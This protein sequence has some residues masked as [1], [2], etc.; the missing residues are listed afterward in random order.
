MRKHD[1]INKNKS[2]KAEVASAIIWHLD[3]AYLE[4]MCK[5]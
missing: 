5:F 2:G 3:N 4:K 1:N